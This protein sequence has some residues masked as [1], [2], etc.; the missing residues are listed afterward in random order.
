MQYFS[1]LS[2]GFPLSTTNVQLKSLTPLLELDTPTLVEN[3]EVF[4]A[5]ILGKV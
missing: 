4:T 1:A 3:G 5:R 2:E